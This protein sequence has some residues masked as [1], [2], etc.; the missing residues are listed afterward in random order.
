MKP[1]KKPYVSSLSRCPVP[2]C[3]QACCTSARG[4]RRIGVAGCDRET[5]EEDWRC[6]CGPIYP[7]AVVG[8]SAGREP[9][10]MASV[11]GLVDS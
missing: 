3:G 1:S 2:R 8:G 11:T 7:L 5:A 9:A 10:E 6:D 4:I